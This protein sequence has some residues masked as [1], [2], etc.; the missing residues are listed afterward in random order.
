MESVIC[1][2]PFNLAKLLYRHILLIFS[3]TRLYLGFVTV[4]ALMM[5]TSQWVMANEIHA[6]GPPPHAPA[7]GY[8]AQHH[9][10]YYPEKQVYFD[11]DRNLYFYLSNGRWISAIS[12]PKPLRLNLGLAVSID[13][14]H[15]KPYLK[16]SVYKKKYP[17]G[18]KHKHK[19]E[20]E[21]E[22]HR[23]PFE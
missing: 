5:N 10:K 23:V 15:D 4:F 6:K 7:H 9:Y 1:L 2:S 8:R 18:K 22:K 19:K 20:R 12:L 11:T 21:K 17:P 14:D 13:L 16:H 3:R